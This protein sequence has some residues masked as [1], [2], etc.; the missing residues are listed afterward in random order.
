[1]L[2][3]EYEIVFRSSRMLLFDLR[4]GKYIVLLFLSVKIDW[5]SRGYIIF[6]LYHPTKSR[7][8]IG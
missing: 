4:T 7:S 3:L 1:M 5:N 2:L 8:L 6:L